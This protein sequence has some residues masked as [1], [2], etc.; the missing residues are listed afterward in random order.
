MIRS[1]LLLDTETTG[2]DEDARCIEVA[3]TLF[4]VEA[5][6]PVSSYSALIFAEE[7]PAARINRIDEA[8]LRRR[9][10]APEVAWRRIDR[11]AE[12]A[13]V[14]VSHG[15]AFDRRFVPSES[16]TK[17][18]PWLC[19]LE[20][21]EW[22]CA[23]KS[24][25]NLVALALA[26]G[27]GVATAHRAAADVDL[28]ARLFGRVKELGFDLAPILRRGL[29]PRAVYQALVPFARKD[30]AKHAGFFWEASTKRWLRTLADEDAN[31]FG[32]PVS[33][34]ADIDRG[35][36]FGGGR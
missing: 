34:V 22:P 15:V 17:T 14:V 29:R 32:F 36:T 21:L 16:F 25:D 30:E 10:L 18:L 35:P 12:T 8:L 6:S 2:T 13:E 24:N 27:L 33:R 28:L 19:S 1:L 31:A 11:I 23:I 9:G 26:H 20:D 5:A 7:N 4:D 3:A